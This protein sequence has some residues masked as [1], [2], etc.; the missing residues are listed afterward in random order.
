MLFV[1]MQSGIIGLIVKLL[2]FIKSVQALSKPSILT[3]VCVCI[4]LGPMSVH[5]LAHSLWLHTWY[6]DLVKQRPECSNILILCYVNVNIILS[7]IFLT[8]Y[9]VSKDKILVNQKLQNIN[10]CII[11]LS[12]SSN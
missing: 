2:L 4:F 6:T 7:I 5:S 3:R 10:A 11:I 8:M 9:F 1:I 12:A